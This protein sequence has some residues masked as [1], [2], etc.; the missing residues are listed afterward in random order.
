MQH[1]DESHQQPR[2][3]RQV[4]E[5]TPQCRRLHARCCWIHYVALEARVCGGV[6]GG[7][8]DRP[9]NEGVQW[10]LVVTGTRTNVARRCTK[11]RQQAV[12]GGGGS[13]GGKVCV[14]RL[15]TTT[16][17]VA[18]P[19]ERRGAAAEER[20]SRCRPL[21]LRRRC[22][23]CLLSAS[24]PPAHRRTHRAAPLALPHYSATRRVL[25]VCVR[26]STSVSVRARSSERVC[27]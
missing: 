5:E 25:V 6:G 26:A 18:A 23:C 17:A 7:G 24:S 3:P 13:G 8:G 12:A 10:R 15:K 19:E 16:A 14:E 2:E 27:D 11:H 20:R 22:F 1:G 9:C 21:R 4:C